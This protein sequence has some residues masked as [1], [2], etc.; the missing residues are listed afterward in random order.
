MS[1][2]SQIVQ[3]R[4]ASRA[5]LALHP[6]DIQAQA[7]NQ[8]RRPGHAI[9]CKIH[10]QPAIPL[11]AARHKIRHRGGGNGDISLET[12]LS[13]CGAKP[14]HGASYRRISKFELSI[15]STSQSKHH[16]HN[17]SKMAGFIQNILWN[18]VEGFVEAG[19]RSAGEYAGNALIKV[20]DAVENGGRS[21]GTGKLIQ[22]LQFNQSSTYAS[23]QASRRKRQTTAPR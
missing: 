22:R 7:T 17:L 5:S 2:S 3:L 12:G 11:S 15:A 18:S 19:K 23:T 8:D 20:G 13:S 14:H 16:R 10:F 21:V 1:F 4:G 9:P 6:D